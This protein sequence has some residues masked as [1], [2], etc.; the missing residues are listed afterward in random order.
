MRPESP[1]SRRERGPKGRVVDDAALA[2]VRALLGTRP[3]HRDL[4]IEHLHLIEH[5]R[6]GRAQVL[7]HL[8]EHLRAT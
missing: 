6:S 7:E 3:R 4:L 1:R 8:I 2:D 5:L